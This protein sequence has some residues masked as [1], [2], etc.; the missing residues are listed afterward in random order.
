MRVFYAPFRALETRFA[1]YASGLKTGPG[2]RVLVLCPSGRAAA[3]LRR[4]LAEKTGLVSNVFFVTFSQLL[5]RLDAQDPAPRAPLLPGD[6][7]HD[8]LLKNLLL[9]PG[10]TGINPAAAFRARCALPC[11]I[12]PIRWP[13]PTCWR[14]IC[15]PLPTPCWKRK[16]RIYSG[17]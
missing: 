12:W 14:S 2:R 7:L 17:W 9:T 16:C 6:N 15:K 4:L 3:R 13:T 5:A 1:A 10:W 11:G 8:Y